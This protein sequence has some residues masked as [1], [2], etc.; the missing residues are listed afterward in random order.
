M[1]ELLEGTNLEFV[2]IVNDI[3]SMY[4]IIEID[5]KLVKIPIVVT[6]AYWNG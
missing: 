3:F 6:E 2:D 4:F 5:K 1:N